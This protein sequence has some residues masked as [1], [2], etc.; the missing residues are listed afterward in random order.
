MDLV[1]KAPDPS[2]P[3]QLFPSLWSCE[4]AL[5]ARCAGRQEA[6]GY[7][8]I[9]EQRL[10]CFLKLGDLTLKIFYAIG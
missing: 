4:R 8:G 3:P 9:M 5:I 2:P 1:L 7:V 10:N 6:C